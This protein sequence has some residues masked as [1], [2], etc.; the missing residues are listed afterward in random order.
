MYRIAKE[1]E[2]ANWENVFTNIG[3][4]YMSISMLP[5]IFNINYGLSKKTTSVV[6]FSN[7][8]FVLPTKVNVKL[9]Y[10]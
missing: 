7:Q 4:I 9:K 3:R 2:N 1:H 5:D 8:F 6:E 10:I